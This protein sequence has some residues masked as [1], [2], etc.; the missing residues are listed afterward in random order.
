MTITERI[1]A[2][3]KVPQSRMHPVLDAPKSVKIELSGRCNYRCGFCALRMRDSQPKA[4]E[5][6]DINLFKQITRQMSDAGVEE[7]GVFFLGESFMNPDLL[8]EAIDWCKRKLAFPYVFCTSNGS[9]AT[10]P[11]LVGVMQAGLDSLKWS[12]NAATAEQFEQIMGVKAHLF[13]A[14]LGN[15][16]VAWRLREA[17]KF[18]TRLYASSIRFDGEQQKKMEALLAERVIPHVDQHY[19][20]PLYSMGSFATQREAELGYRPTAGNQGRIGALRAPL[21]CWSAFTEGHVRA[22]GGLSACCFDAGGQWLMGDLTTES[23]MDS[24]NSDKFQALRLAHLK[25]DVSGT[26]CEDCVA[27]A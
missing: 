2:I 18:K 23:F 12:V 19:W 27:Y 5:D 15:I 10:L 8:I 7:I 9:L 26:I 16:E 20:L 13:E 24:W 1:D 11:R 3:T 17:R 22:D 21:P 14:S 4:S 6:M 25:K